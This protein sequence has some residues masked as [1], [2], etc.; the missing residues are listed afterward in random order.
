MVSFA[1]SISIMTFLNPP[2]SELFYISHAS[3]QKYSQMC[4]TYMDK[5]QIKKTT[6]NYI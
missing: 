5:G 3:K 2:N 6:T 1:L 4:E